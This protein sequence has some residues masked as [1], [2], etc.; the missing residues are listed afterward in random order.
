MHSNTKYTQYILTHRHV[1]Y[2]SSTCCDIFLL[3]FILTSKSLGLF[4]F[5]ING[6]GFAS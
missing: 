2:L 4:K 5:R 3:D 6:D 1:D